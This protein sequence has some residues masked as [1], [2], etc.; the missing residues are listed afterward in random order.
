MLI[1]SRDKFIVSWVKNDKNNK[2]LDVSFPI[3]E[4]IS[5]FDSFLN[6]NQREQIIKDYNLVKK[7]I[8]DHDSSKIIKS[9]YS[10]VEDID[11]N[12]KKSDI[13][14]YKLSELIYWFKTPQK[15]WLNKKNISPKEIFIHHPDDEYVSN[16]QKSQLITKII[17]ELEIDNHNVIY[18]LKNLNINDQLVE[19]GI[20]IP[21]NSI[22]IKEKIKDL[23]GSLSASLS[24][25]NKINRI[26]VKSNAN[27]RIFRC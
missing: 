6:Q 13:K 17:K 24:Q 23:L 3:K 20:F 26:Y 10:L 18:D 22:Y 12:E 5:F 9:N 19:N 11:W 27:R 4:L 1:A 15:Y 16:L 2:K 21:K 8:I 7:E 14:N 25:D